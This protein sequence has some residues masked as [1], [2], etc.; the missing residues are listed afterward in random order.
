MGAKKQRRL[1]VSRLLQGHRLR[2]SRAFWNAM[3]FLSIADRMCVLAALSGAVHGL[4][5][6]MKKIER[7][8]LR[9]LA[10]LGVREHKLNDDMGG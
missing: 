1:A 8:D 3:S 6:S 4:S 5:A 2:L 9:T 7:D 10:E